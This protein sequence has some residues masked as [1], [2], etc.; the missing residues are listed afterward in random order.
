MPKKTESP[1]KTSAATVVLDLGSYSAK[2]GLSSDAAPRI[3]PNC[4][5]K[6][7]SEK[8]R[9]FVSGQISECKVGSIG[10]F[11][12]QSVD[13]L[14]DW[15]NDWGTDYWIAYVIIWL[16]DWLKQNSWL[17]FVRSIDWLID[18]FSRDDFPLW[19]DQVLLGHFTLIVFH[20]SSFR[21]IP[22]STSTF[23][24]VSLLQWHFNQLGT[25]RTNTRLLFRRR[26]PQYRQ[27]ILTYHCDWALLQFS[28]CETSVC[29]SDIW[30][31]V[32]LHDRSFEQCESIDQSINQS[33]IWLYSW[34]CESVTQYHLVKKLWILDIKMH[35]FF[36]RFFFTTSSLNFL[37]SFEKLILL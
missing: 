28:Q 12:I 33:I 20:L 4:I 5:F 2:I 6:A 15:M 8:K 27:E 9:Q 14:I 30:R 31:F 37:Q 24:H 23:S 32:L 35:R 13:R 17:L 21:L 34:T 19:F 16:I 11:N 18:A 3:L 36:F 25:G 22:G 29:R 10:P 26:S 7:K 1:V